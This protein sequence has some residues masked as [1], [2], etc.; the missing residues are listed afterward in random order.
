MD[1]VCLPTTCALYHHRGI[2]LGRPAHKRLKRTA[3][4]ASHGTSRQTWSEKLVTVLSLTRI[5]PRDDK[6]L[7]S[8]VEKQQ[9]AVQPQKAPR[10]LKTYPIKSHANGQP[11][12]VRLCIVSWQHH[13]LP[14][15]Q[16]GRTLLHGH[17]LAQRVLQATDE[18]HRTKQRPPVSG[19]HCF[20][21]L[22]TSHELANWPGNLI[23]QLRSLQTKK[24]ATLA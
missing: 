12:K 20:E 8:L 21:L 15:R 24:S 11:D 16:N 4:F 17:S 7:L 3:I 13:E 5:N 9:P 22:H 23:K 1:T 2:N 18:C 19:L 10:R 6:I 14:C